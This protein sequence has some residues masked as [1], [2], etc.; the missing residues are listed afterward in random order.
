MI[1]DPGA[2]LAYSCCGFFGL[3]NFISDLQ[4]H[5]LQVFQRILL[6]EVVEVLLEV[7]VGGVF[8]AV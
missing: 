6:T 2:Y 7:F 3:A 1:M 4:P 5:L 8:H